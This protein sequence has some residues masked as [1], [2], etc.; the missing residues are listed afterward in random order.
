MNQMHSSRSVHVLVFE[1][2]ADWEPAHAL[3]EI[4]RVG[5]R[6]IRTVGFSNASVHSMGGIHVLPH[7]TL[8]DMRPADVEMLLLPGGDLWATGD[9]PRPQL[10]RLLHELVSAEV[11]VAAICGATIALAR[12]GIL[13]DRQHTSTMR[14][15]LA[16]CGL[17][18]TGSTLYRDALV[19]RD[20]RVITASGLGAVDFARAIFRELGVFD[21]QNEQLWFDMYKQGKL[22]GAAN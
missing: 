3:A 20:R 18:Y 7:S 11:P 1:G 10:E 6:S 12:A 13:N 5:K 2:F 15:D 9:Y 17:E 14:S 4:R 22:P 21:E 19:V 16:A 8:S